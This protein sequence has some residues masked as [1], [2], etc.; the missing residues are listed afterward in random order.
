MAEAVIED[1]KCIRFGME[2]GILSRDDLGIFRSLLLPD[3]YGQFYM[4]F[5]EFLKQFKLVTKSKLV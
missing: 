1:K 3:T 4:E 5:D 2:I